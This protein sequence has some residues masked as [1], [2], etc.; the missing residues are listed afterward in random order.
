MPHRRMR[1]PEGVVSEGW[2]GNPGVTVLYSPGDTAHPHGLRGRHMKFLYAVKG[3]SHCDSRQDC[4]KELKNS[5]ANLSVLAK[6]I[7]E[8][9]QRWTSFCKDFYRMLRLPK[10]D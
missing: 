6:I 1:F 2:V 9:T 4:P 8:G 3:C 7:E 10:K 5:D